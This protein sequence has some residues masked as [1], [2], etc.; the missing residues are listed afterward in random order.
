MNC[1]KLGGLAKHSEENPV[2][3]PTIKHIADQCCI[4][5][6]SHRIDCEVETELS[7]NTIA[8][9]TKLCKLSPH[10]LLGDDFHKSK[11]TNTKTKIM[12]ELLVELL[13]HVVVDWI[14]FQM[15]EVLF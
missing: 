9:L 11:S 14:P 4:C 8:H 7:S 2:D 12:D 5:F 6:A 10:Q 13:H 3:N 15:S 1:K